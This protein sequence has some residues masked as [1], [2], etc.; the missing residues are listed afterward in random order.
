M[1][2]LPQPAASAAP[3]GPS[4]RLTNGPQAKRI[5]EL[6]SRVGL[7]RSLGARFHGMEEVVGSIPT[8][9]TNRQIKERVPACREGCRFDSVKAHHSFVMPSVY[10]LESQSSKRF[11]IGSANDVEIRLAAHQRGQTPSTRGRGPWVPVYREEFDTIAEARQR[12]RQ[13][14]S[15]KSHRSIQQLIDLNR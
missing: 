2:R 6:L 12:E 3:F 15:W 5:E 14:K 9:S 8:R 11:Y 13:L 10:I 4:T 7:W 1:I